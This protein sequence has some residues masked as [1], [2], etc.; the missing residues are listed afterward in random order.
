MAEHNELGRRGEDRAAT[1]LKQNGYQILAR[2]YSFDRAEVDLICKQN[3]KLIV[4]EVKTRQSSYLAG[5]NETVTPAKQRQII[6]AA[7]NFIQEEEL[8]LDC[9]FDIISIILNKKQFELD[10]IKDAFF[11]S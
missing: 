4:V 9:Q 3:D 11:P 1:Y 10:H 7:N 6:K 5:P 8:D 2:N